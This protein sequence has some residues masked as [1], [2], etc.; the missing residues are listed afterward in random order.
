MSQSDVLMSTATNNN[1]QNNTS[2]QTLEELDRQIKQAEMI[3]QYLQVTNIDRN[4]LSNRQR[5]T[6]EPEP[7]STPG[8]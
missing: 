4:S 3:R 6:S 2:G 8:N 1:N 7:S 5:T